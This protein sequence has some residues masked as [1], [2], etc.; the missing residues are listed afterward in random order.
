MLPVYN[1]KLYTNQ[2][3][4]RKYLNEIIVDGNV[5]SF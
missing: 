2:I 1:T 3:P 4:N 5:T